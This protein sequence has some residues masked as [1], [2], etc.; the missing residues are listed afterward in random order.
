MIFI[1]KISRRYKSRGP[2]ID[3]PVICRKSYRSQ[4]VDFSIDVVADFRTFFEHVS[5]LDFRQKR[6]EPFYRFWQNFDQIFTRFICIDFLGSLYFHFLRLFKT[7]FISLGYITLLT[8]IF[9]HWTSSSSIFSFI[10]S[11]HS[12][13]SLRPFFFCL[14]VFFLVSISNIPTRTTPIACTIT[15]D[16]PDSKLNFLIF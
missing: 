7:T 3:I 9:L 12:F 13:F 6:P 11:L 5:G 14:C 10:L 4:K 1:W 15:N 2:Q 8:L 16:V